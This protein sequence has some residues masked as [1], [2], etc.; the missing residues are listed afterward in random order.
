MPSPGALPYKTDKDVHR[1]LELNLKK[2]PIWHVGVVQTY[3][4]LMETVLFH[5]MTAFV[6]HIEIS[7]R[8]NLYQ[9]MRLVYAGRNIGFP[10]GDS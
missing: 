1:K 8:T 9:E 6:F 5:S 3:L 10:S 7:R 4:S 2:S